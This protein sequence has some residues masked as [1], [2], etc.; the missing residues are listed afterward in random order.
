M[1]HCLHSA[2]YGN[3][4]V[5]VHSVSLATEQTQLLR[6]PF[7]PK[8]C[9]CNAFQQHTFLCMEPDPSVCRS[10]PFRNCGNS[11][12]RL[13][14]VLEWALD[15]LEM[16]GFVYWEIW[17]QCCCLTCQVLWLTGTYR[18][19]LWL[20]F[21]FSLSV[22]AKPVCCCSSILFLIK[23]PLKLLRLTYL[24]REIIKH[25]SCISSLNYYHCC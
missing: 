8:V 22:K 12:L 20:W 16:L 1:A 19:H 14:R 21:T 4:P 17:W 15:V 10:C 9:A 7:L 13:V 5:C 18:K 23:K 2:L 6:E 11:S 3:A 25:N 24:V